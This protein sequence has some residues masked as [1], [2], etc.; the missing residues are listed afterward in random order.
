MNQL[1]VL[2]INNCKNIHT[3]PQLNN[4]NVLNINNCKYIFTIPQLNKL[5]RLCVKNCNYLIYKQCDLLKLNCLNISNCK[6]IYELTNINNIDY[7]LYNHFQKHKERILKFVSINKIKNWYKRMK[8]IEKY[9]IIIEYVE[10]KRMHPNS[11]YF[12]K[13]LDSLE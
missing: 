12:K 11:M 5:N 13:I 9:Y 4:L 2:N 1:I 3:I 7:N 6:N 8:L 10:K